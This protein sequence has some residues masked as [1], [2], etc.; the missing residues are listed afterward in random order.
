MIPIRYHHA[1]EQELLDEIAYLERGAAG[2]GR[3]YFE[4]IQRAESVLAQFPE[5]APE[6]LPGVHKRILRKFPF[7]FN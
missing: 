5:S 7:I 4:E 2:L 6:L 3:R 1:A